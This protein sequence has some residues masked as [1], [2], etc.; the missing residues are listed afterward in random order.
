MI[1]GL[2]YEG[3]AVVRREVVTSIEMVRIRITDIGRMALEG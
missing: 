1:A 2:V 3:L